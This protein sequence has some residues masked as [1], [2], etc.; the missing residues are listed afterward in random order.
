MPTRGKNYTLVKDRESQKLNPTPRAHA[1]TARENVPS[2]SLAYSQCN[3]WKSP[4]PPPSPPSPPRI[5]LSACVTEFL[6][7]ANHPDFSFFL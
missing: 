3:V 7:V 1:H 4:P 5:A 2:F 6:P